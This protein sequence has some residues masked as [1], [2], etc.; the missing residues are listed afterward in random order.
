MVG[1]LLG[2]LEATG[3]RDNTIVIVTSDHGDMLGERGLWYKMHFYEMAARVPLVVH[4]PDRFTARRIGKNVSLLD[5]F[6]TLMD[7]AGLDQSGADASD[8]LVRLRQDLPGSSLLPALSGDAERLPDHVLAEYLSESALGP[9]LMIRRG[10]HKYVVGEGSPAQ[11]FAPEAD[12]MEVT[13]LA[14]NPDHA[15]IES[16]F[17]DEVAKTWNQEKLKAEVIAS[18]QRRLLVDKAAKRGRFAPWD[19]QPFSD[20]SQLYARNVSDTLGDQERGM[21]LPYLDAPEPDGRG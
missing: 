2:A 9:L 5:L 6:P 20:A 13:N 12:P 11:L 8:A 21:R 7:L 15:E 18:Q 10:A 3:Q 19:F 17:A 14:G 16:G 1:E 4:A